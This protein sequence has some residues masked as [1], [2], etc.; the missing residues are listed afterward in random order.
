M[1]LSGL[2]PAREQYNQAIADALGGAYQLYVQDVFGQAAGNQTYYMAKWMKLKAGTYTAV[3]YVDDSGTLS[4]DHAVVATA[5]IGTNPNSGEFTIAADGVYRFDCIYSNVPADTP[6]YM[7]YQLIR[8]GQTVEVSRANDFIADIVPIPDKALGPKPPYSDDVR[9]TYPVFL[10]LP[11]WKD[12][13]TERIEWQTDVMISES[14]AE[15]RRPIRLHP[16]RSFEATFLRWEENRTLLD[17]TIAGVG[18]SPLLLPLWHDMTA[19]ENNAPAGSVDIFGQFRVKDFNVGDVVMFNRGT[20]WDYETNIIAGL[21]IDAGHMTLT[22]GLQS[23]TPKGTR[24]Y[25]VRV[26]Q[27]REAMNGQQM[28]DSVSQTQV[29]FFCTENYDLTPS[30]SDFPIY[31]RTGLHIFVLPEDWG[32]SNEITSDRLT[33]NFDNQSG[34]VVVVDPGGQNYGTVKKSYTIKGR[35]ADRQFRQILFALRG[36]TKT[37][38]LPLDTNDFILSRDINPADGALVVRRCGY[39]QYIGGTQETKRDIMVELYDGT[40]IPTTIISSR[41]VGGEEWLFL[42]QSIP[43]TSRNDVRRIGYIPVARLDV[44]GIEIKRLTDS[45]GVSQVS[46]TFKFFDDRRIATPLPLS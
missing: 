28:T 27:I 12:G 19:T 23:D 9:L 44:D 43:A 39:T 17:T 31:T 21:D 24:L 32:S 30:W 5:A 14:G 38:H 41:I 42:S 7:A 35:T 26:A 25:P 33:Y 34:P 36:R 15:Q 4:I 45:A 37:F 46:L 18:Q 16:R 22:F 6:A 29:R 10:P 40:R 11:N 20:T 13:V 1:A 3:M 2:R 8:D